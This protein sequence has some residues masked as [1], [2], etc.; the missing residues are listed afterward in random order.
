MCS[1]SS[2]AILARPRRLLGRVSRGRWPASLCRR[3]HARRQ[4]ICHRHPLLLNW[5]ARFEP[6]TEWRQIPN[7]PYDISDDGQIR[8]TGSGRGATAGRILKLKASKDGYIR[9]ALYK[10]DKKFRFLFHRLVALVFHGKPPT[11]R[12]DAA[13]D[14]GNKANNSPSNIVWK[15]R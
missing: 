9:L 3:W 14:D 13:H 12:Y 8:R 7:L 4:W 1:S 11:K 15:T 2:R 5:A 10:N 6:M